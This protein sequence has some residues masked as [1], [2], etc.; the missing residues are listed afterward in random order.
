M[1]GQ[2]IAEVFGG[3]GLSATAADRVETVKPYAVPAWLPAGAGMSRVEFDMRLDVTSVTHFVEAPR[4]QGQCLFLYHFGHGEGLNYRE[5]D[6]IPKPAEPEPGV[7]QLLWPIVDQGCDV[8]LL[9]MPFQ[10]DNLRTLPPGTTKKQWQN[11]VAAH[12]ALRPLE[13]ADWTPMVYFLEPVVRAINFATEKKHYRTIG[14]AGKSGGGW[15]T[16]VAG[17][18][19]ARIQHAYSVAGSMPEYYREIRAADRGDWE[20]Q[21]SRFWAKA[22]YINLYVLGALDDGKSMD[23]IWRKYDSCCFAGHRANAFMPQ[24]IDLTRRAGISDLSFWVETEPEVGHFLSLPIS[25]RIAA[26]FLSR[27]S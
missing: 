9:S 25:R 11:G 10:G 5:Q 21:G 4:P 2:L 15:T 3:A 20:Q 6:G 16:V 23:L 12:N 17:A 24:L 14:M 18:L 22:D 19:D 8:L 27:V 1:R 7:K 26:N 13:T